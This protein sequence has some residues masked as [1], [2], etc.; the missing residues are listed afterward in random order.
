MNIAA[1]IAGD[2]LLAGGTVSLTQ[3][4]G[5]DVR[6][7]GLRVSLAGPIS[8]DIAAAGG[9]LRVLSPAQTLYAA[10][11]SID[12]EGGSTGD[13]TLYGANIFLS[14]EYGGN[15]KIVA[16]NRLT[17]GSDTHIHG[18]LTYSSPERLVV[19][20]GAVIDG[21]M[22]Y[23]GA[24]AYVPTT[25]RVHQYALIGT[26]LFFAVRVLA[27]IIVAGLIAGFFP[28]F[29]V[30][31]SRLLLRKNLS[32][33]ARL[34]GIGIVLAALT[35]FLCLFL[36]ISF[37]G[38]GLAL[39]LILLYALL[40]ILSYAFCGI[41]VGAFLRHSLLYKLRGEREFMWQDAVLG[42]LCIHAIGLIPV[43]GTIAV[44][45]LAIACAGALAYL[46]YCAAFAHSH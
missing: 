2:A 25:K 21:G 1:P 37:V 40:I 32:A 5:G 24:Y 17:L 11:G 42:T 46:S 35:P 30:R 44:I 6:V 19:P 39:L 13:V 33:L 14:G 8:G 23:T 9:T 3:G 29:C 27:G 26:I 36:L 43:V 10:G 34:F 12:A 18:A 28:L 16:S 31:V 20:D 4:A 38:A 7:A 15:V 22:H 45:L 41:V